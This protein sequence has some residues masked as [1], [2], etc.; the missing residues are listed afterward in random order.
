MS[1][2]IK[3]CSVWN[4]FPKASSLESYI[5]NKIKDIQVELIS[6]GGGVFEVRFNKELIFSKK[7]IGR[8]PENS[9]IV[10][11]IIEKSN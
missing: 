11:L 3:Y 4:Y 6:G 7:S 1:V 5:K 9:E 2:S 8:F 10:N